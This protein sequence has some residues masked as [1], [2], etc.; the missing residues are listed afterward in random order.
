[1]PLRKY[2]GWFGT[3]RKAAKRPP[4]RP[5]LRVQNLEARL[6]PAGYLAIGAGTGSAPWVAVRVDIKD[7]LAGDPP[8]NLGQPPDPRSDGKT[9]FTSQIFMPFVSNFRGGVHTATGNFDGDATTPDSLVTAAGPSGGPH[10]IVWNMIQ[11]PDG[12]IVTNGIRDQFFAFDHRFRGGVNVTT[13]DLDGDGRAE[14]ICAAGAGGG[15]HV[16][17]FKDVN[18]KFVLANEFFAYDPSFRGGVNVASGQGYKINVQQ[19]LVLSAQLPDGFTE[20]PYAALGLN[21]PGGAFDIPLVSGVTLDGLGDAP[22]FPGGNAFF[23][24]NG[25][26]TVPQGVTSHRDGNGDPLPYITVAGGPI[27]MLSANLTN[28]FGA[29]VYRPDIFRTDDSGRGEIVFASWTAQDVPPGFNPDTVYGPFVR[30]SRSS[31]PT[32]FITPLSPSPNETQ[33]LNGQPINFANQLVVGAGPGGGPHVKVYSFVGNG[34]QFQNLGVGKEFF[35]FDPTFTGGITV[36]V[37]DVI[38]TNNTGNVVNGESVITGGRR[39]FTQSPP[40]FI[41]DTQANSGT[42]AFL[43]YPFSTTLFEKLKPDIIVGMASGGSAVRFFGD[44]ASFT[45]DPV[46]PRSDPI[47]AQRTNISQL[48]LVAYAID[49]A[50]GVDPTNPLGGY[51]NL[52]SSTSFLRA[53]DNAASFAGGVTVGAAAFRFEGSMETDFY[54]QS[55]LGAGTPVA[56]NPAFAEPLFAAGRA[57][58]GQAGRGSRVRIFNQTGIF[59]PSEP[60]SFVYDDFQAFSD[61]SIQG[62]SVS[63]GFGVL[64]DNANALDVIYA[65]YN[66][67]I[68]GDANNNQLALYAPETV[69]A[70]VLVF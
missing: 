51:Y 27:Q 70:S 68:A 48:N 19:R 21:K 18:G 25:G 10:V 39:D 32:Q 43:N 6:T 58:A 45:A 38:A 17:I 24:P 47:P 2:L 66:A 8:N 9:E 63:F 13:G 20:I 28:T 5:H 41:R 60:E 36:A 34:N 44:V 65:N 15:P 46:N 31:D 49:A 54:G 7:A 64:P 4:A 62:I 11:R 55:D 23:G 26:Y 33:L 57:P 69:T 30:L 22:V 40:P 16:K 50:I 1:M 42:Q 59:H 56:F 35:A 67:G 61:P 52:F 53:V 12:G 14:L 29:S 3:S 37:N